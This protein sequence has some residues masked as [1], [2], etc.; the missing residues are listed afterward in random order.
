[1]FSLVEEVLHGLGRQNLRRDAGRTINQCRMIC[2]R[3]YL[4]GVLMDDLPLVS[5]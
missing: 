4:T 5:V 1:M 3:V 2:A